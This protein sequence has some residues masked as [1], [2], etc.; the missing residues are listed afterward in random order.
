MERGLEKH[1][2]VRNELGD[3]CTGGNI[4]LPCPPAHQMLSVCLHSTTI[5]WSGASPL[6]GRSEGGGWSADDFRWREGKLGDLLLLI[7]S[8]P[9][10]GH[11]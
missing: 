3:S 7:N 11:R 8:Y 1:S 4:W 6:L 5:I 2:W 10:M 9:K